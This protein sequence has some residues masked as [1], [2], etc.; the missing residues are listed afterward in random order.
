MIDIENVIFTKVATALRSEYPGIQVY[1]EYVE[2][3]EKFPFVSFVEDDNYTY[4]RTQTEAENEN[5]VNVFYTLNVYTN[6][7]SNKKFVAKDIV[8]F[9]DNLLKDYNFDRVMMSQI[10]N[11]D[12]TVYRIVARYRAVVQKGIKDGEDDLFYVYRR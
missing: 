9:V 5:H 2:K 8:A 10:P 3:P 7:A 1:G 11:V 4:E 6:N 12:R